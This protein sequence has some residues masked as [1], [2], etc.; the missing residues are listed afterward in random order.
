MEALISQFTFLSD[1]ACYDKA[2]DPS[3]IEDLINL[4]E[5]EAYKSWAAMEL[6]HQ[7]EVQQA[8]IEM[9]QAEDYLD[10]VMESAM[11]EFRQFEEEMERTSKKEMEELVETAERARKMGKLMDKAA[12]VASISPFTCYAD[13]YFFIFGDS[14]YDVGNNQYLVEPGRYISAYH[15]PYG[16]TFFNHA[17]GR[18]SDG[19]APP[20]FIG[21]KIVV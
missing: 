9:K 11:D 10:S 2:F 7:N 5:V 14:L 1:Q 8:E 21:K 12:S 15:K 18:F 6:E 4:F 3:T 16:T 20:D 13:Y 19:R 17:T